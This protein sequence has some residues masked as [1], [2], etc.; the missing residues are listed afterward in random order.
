MS[1]FFLYSC[2]ICT[3]YNVY[4]SATAWGGGDRLRKDFTIAITRIAQPIKHAINGRA[5]SMRLVECAT[6]C[7][8][9]HVWSV[10]GGIVAV[11]GRWNRPKEL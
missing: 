2:D 1:R 8:W 11:W 6:K 10:Y 9:L 7:G 5:G 4:L 3:T